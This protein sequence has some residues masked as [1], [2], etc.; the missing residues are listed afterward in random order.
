MNHDTTQNGTQCCAPTN[1]ANACTPRA[2]EA[3]SAQ[4]DSAQRF[5]T[6]PRFRATT[7]SDAVTLHVELPGVGQDGVTLTV[8]AD[9]LTL[10]AKHS[11]ATPSADV[12]HRALEFRLADYSRRWRL[13]ENVEVDA[14]TSTLRNGIL[15]IV[16]P[17]KKPARRAIAIA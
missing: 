3:S 6:T 16:L 8:E 9:V 13:P 15:E 1:G 7:G 5:V 2:K 10:E 17:L 14:I 11:P 12:V 4:Q